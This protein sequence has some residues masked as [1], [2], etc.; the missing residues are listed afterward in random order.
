MTN[1]APWQVNFFFALAGIFRNSA[2]V[3]RSHQWRLIRSNAAWSKHP[4]LWR[5]G[6]SSPPH[7]PWP[8]VH[9]STSVAEPNFHYSRKI[10][11]GFFYAIPS[12][13]G[14]SAAQP[15]HGAAE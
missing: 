2:D 12:Q 14:R 5:T 4:V 9:D 8:S 13:R 15:L 6:L 11:S 3:Y 7:D 1:K 10:A